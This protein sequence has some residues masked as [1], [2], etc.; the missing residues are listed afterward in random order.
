MGKRRFQHAFDGFAKL[1]AWSFVNSTTTFFSTDFIQSRSYIE[2]NASNDIA[3]YMLFAAPIPDFSWMQKKLTLFRGGYNLPV[4]VHRFGPPNDATY[5]ALSDVWSVYTFDPKSLKTHEFLNAPIPGPAPSLGAGMNLAS[6]SHPLPEYG[7]DNLITFV[8][9]TDPIFSS[10]TS[11]RLVRITSGSGREMIKDI[12]VPE[13]PYMH[14]FGLSKN[15]ATIMAA[16]MF[17]DVGKILSTGNPLTSMVWRA[18]EGLTIHVVHIKTGQLF[19]VHTDAMF[20][21]HFINSHEGG[22]MVYI[23]YVVYPD[24]DLLSSLDL[25]IMLNPDA[26]NQL[27]MNAQMTRFAINITERSVQVLHFLTSPGLEFVNSF[28]FPAVNPRFSYEN[29]CY[30]YGLVGKID[31]ENMSKGGLVKK[32]ICTSGN[33]IIWHEEHHYPAE[34]IFIP[35]PNGTEEDDGIL[36]SVVLDGENG[37]SYLGVFDAGTLTLRSKSYLPMSLPL[38]IHGQ[39]FPEVLM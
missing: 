29:Y 11:I 39:F 22:D 37:L 1:C 17:V 16:P 14:S 2:S 6:S 12:P 30:V 23:D 36:L 13:V 3:P 10:H 8:G 28:D 18:E 5:V 35:N 19:S 24:M 33:D 9:L 25:S 32:D 38:N 27:V 20:P 31:G 4:N 26:R 21:M 15:Y 7:T 34:P